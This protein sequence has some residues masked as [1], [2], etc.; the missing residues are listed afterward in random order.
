MPKP[1]TPSVAQ[2][3]Q[4][5]PFHPGQRNAAQGQTIYVQQQHGVD[6][7]WIAIASVTATLIA[8]L[9]VAVVLWNYRN[10]PVQQ[11]AP[12]IINVNSGQHGTT[13]VSPPAAVAAAAPVSPP[14]DAAVVS[15]SP[16][17]APAPVASSPATP[18]VKSTPAATPAAPVA[19]AAP[20]A[21]TQPA[22]AAPVAVTPPAKPPGSAPGNAPSVKR[23]VPAP[24]SAASVASAAG[25]APRSAIPEA[26]ENLTK[27][28]APTRLGPPDPTPSADPATASATASNAA[29]APEAPADAPRSGASKTAGVIV[30]WNEANQYMGKLITIEGTVVATRNTGSVCFLN[31]D[32]NWRDKFYIIVEPSVMNAW[33]KPPQDHFL[34]QKIRVT[35]KVTIY[36]D[37]PQMRI[38]QADQITIV[39]E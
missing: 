16:T 34:N 12:L 36:Q 15:A 39:A 19:A 13:S 24:A 5:G 1:V 27:P 14:P 18:A 9:F 21:T 6:P 22:A 37:R 2:P 11:Q 3:R 20:S 10:Q 23:D 31:F 25:S 30:P 7:R 28:V 4:A 29:P 26:G 32:K 17:S 35:G 38:N 33:P 8:L